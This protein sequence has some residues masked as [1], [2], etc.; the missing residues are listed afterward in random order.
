MEIIIGI[1]NLKRSFNNPVVAFGNFDGV[2]LGHQKIFKRVKEEAL[3]IGGEGIVITFEPHPL[4]VLSPSHCP[5]LLTPFRKKMMLIEPS[6]I[7][8]VF[9][10]G[11]T[12]A[13]S[14]LSPVEFVKS[15]LMGKINPRKIIVGY[16]YHFGRKKSGDA[17]TLK[18]LCKPYQVE[19]EI[20]EPLI[21]DGIPVSSSRV[22]ELIK[23]GKMEEASRLL[24]RDYLIIGKVIEGAKAGKTLGFPTANLGISDELYP[25]MGV[26]AVDVIWNQQGYQ[27]VANLG[28]NL[29]FQKVYGGPQSP[30]SLEVYILSFNQMIYGEEIQIRFKKRIRDEIR[31]ESSDQLIDQIRKDIQW[32][33][34]NVF[35][36][37]IPV[38]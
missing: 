24:G 20:V 8:T 27:G 11:F 21:I 18:V 6:G 3:K 23:N 36:N 34:E 17:K 19:V 35:K 26:Y 12:L 4:K 2:H 15:I 7:Q 30:L 13:L 14:E 16:N 38:P 37:L 31:F 10:I 9:C 1:E 29:T 33:Q 22:R 28:R 32:A 5:P 25:L